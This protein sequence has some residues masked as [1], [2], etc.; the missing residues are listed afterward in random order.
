M[1]A[2]APV[3]IPKGGLVMD[4]L[5]EGT[6]PSTP[7]TQ[8]N[9]NS[10]IGSAG[11]MFTATLDATDPNF[12][13][14]FYFTAGRDTYVIVDLKTMQIVDQIDALAGGSSAAFAEFDMLLP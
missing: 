1:V 7:A 13:L 14:E 4:V 8:A 3:W 5:V 2:K 9:L 6:T 10:W 11:E 12:A